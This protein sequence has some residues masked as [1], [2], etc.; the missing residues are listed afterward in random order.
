M[1]NE[2]QLSDAAIDAFERRD[3]MVLARELGQRPW[4]VSPLDVHD[5]PCPYPGTC[6]GS[7]S[8]PAAQRVRRVLERALAEKKYRGRRNGSR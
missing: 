2:L 6:A 5:G 4:Q 1:T 8:W 7:A 3:W